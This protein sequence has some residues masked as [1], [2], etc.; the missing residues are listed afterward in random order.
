MN[1][2]SNFRIIRRVVKMRKG[3]EHRRR[4]GG[5]RRRH[6]MRRQ[7]IQ[8]CHAEK[9]QGDRQLGFQQFQHAHHTG[10]TVGGQRAAHHA[11][12]PDQI[13]AKGDRFGDI[14]AA[15]DAPVDD[16]LGLAIDG[17]DHFR[18]QRHRA[19]AMVDLPAAMVGDPK[20]FDPHLHCLD[21]VS[22]VLNA[23]QGQRQ[24]MF[25]LVA[26]D[27]VPIELR[28]PIAAGTAGHPGFHEAF[29]DIALRRL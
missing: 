23:F 16:D 5:R 26:F 7:L 3:A 10:L 12:E 4:H 17:G 19:L 18:Q 28:L 27:V 29:G 22:R 25:I 20:D 13:G 1:V 14:A 9:A 15:L 6:I 21:R 24:F 2:K 8:G 11:A